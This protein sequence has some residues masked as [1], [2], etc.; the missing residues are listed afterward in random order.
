MGEDNKG[1]IRV[2]PKLALIS[3]ALSDVFPKGKSVVVFS[4]NDEDFF[5][6][7]KTIGVMS[8]DNQ[9]KIVISDIE[10]IFI[11]ETTLDSSNG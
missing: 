7:K 8:D 9:F 1:S 5:N 11:R 2:M 4:L 3:E 10:F 6:M